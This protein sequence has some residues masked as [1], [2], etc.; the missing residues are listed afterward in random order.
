MSITGI[1]VLVVYLLGIVGNTFYR[2]RKISNL[3][4]FN[5][6]FVPVVLSLGWPV[7]VPWDVCQWLYWKIRIRL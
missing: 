5:S 6:W 7:S 1:I 2:R 3:S 4:G